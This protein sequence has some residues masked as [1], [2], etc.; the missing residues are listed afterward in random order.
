M[1]N[2]KAELK[3]SL[4]YSIQKFIREFLEKFKDTIF[5]FFKRLGFSE[6]TAGVGLVI[7]VVFMKNYEEVKKRIREFLD[8]HET[9]KKIIEYIR[10][11]LNNLVDF[12]NSKINDLFDLFKKKVSIETSPVKESY[13]DSIKERFIVFAKNIREKFEKGSLDSVNFLYNLFFVFAYIFLFTTLCS[14]VYEKSLVSIH[15]SIFEKLVNSFFKFIDKLKNN[16]EEI[17][18][19][20]SEEKLKAIIK[21]FLMPFQTVLDT[22]LELKDDLILL[23]KYVSVIFGIVIIYHLHYS[24]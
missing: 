19:V 17:F 5:D 14:L 4:T 13:L 24:V 22:F 3:A 12:I 20:S 6:K 1:K 15:F 8:S 16:F 23:V 7:F 2:T 21:L 10:I 18:Y 9:L 11:H